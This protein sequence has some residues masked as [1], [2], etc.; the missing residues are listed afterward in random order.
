MPPE[1]KAK[2]YEVIKALSAMRLVKEDATPNAILARRK[3]DANG[4]IKSPYIPA[5]PTAE[6]SSVPEELN[7]QVKPE[8][9]GEPCVFQGSIGAA[10]NEKALQENG[11]THILTAASK[12]GQRFKGK[13]TYKV[14]PLLDS[15]SQNIVQFFEEACEW[16]DTVLKESPTHRVLIHCFAGK[17][18]ASTITC[19]FLMKKQGLT[20]REALLHTRACRPIA[21]PNIGFLVQL[22]AF[23]S[24]VHGQCSDVP[25]RLEK[26]FGCA[27]PTPQQA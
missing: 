2:L 5:L 18:R 19:A 7:W 22:K 23:E 17:S 20:L 26:L 24:T 16:V 9:I 27:P 3:P 6:G 14:L 4:E 1:A 12:I 15:P 11:I 25:L 21:W 13:L 8:E 10:Y